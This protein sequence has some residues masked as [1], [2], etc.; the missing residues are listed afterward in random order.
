M[1]DSAVVIPLMQ[2]LYSLVMSIAGF[3]W[4]IDNVILLAAYFIAGVR[5]AARGVG[6]SPLQ[7]LVRV[8]LPLAAPARALDARRDAEDAPQLVGRQHGE[9]GEERRRGTG[10]EH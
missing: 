6:M 1:I 2:A 9:V 7:S 4:L 10:G 5:E 3:M 8:E